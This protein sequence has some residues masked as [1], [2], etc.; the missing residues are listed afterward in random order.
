[1]A[2]N[3]LAATV[4]SL[5]RAWAQRCRR[6][7]EAQCAETQTKDREGQSAQRN[8]RKQQSNQNDHEGGQ[9]EGRDGQGQHQ[10]A[11]AC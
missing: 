10:Q 7:G 3:P 4:A 5:W 1:M 9:H 2:E 11:D 6:A 8:Q